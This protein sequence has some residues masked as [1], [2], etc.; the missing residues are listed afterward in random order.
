MA[1]MF[2]DT[3][4]SSSM[5][6]PASSSTAGGSASMRGFVAEFPPLLEVDR[7]QPSLKTFK[8]WPSSSDLFESPGLT[9]L[10]ACSRHLAPQDKPASRV[11]PGLTWVPIDSLSK[12]G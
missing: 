1:I 3:G 2:K 7:V 11:P 8:V 10:S 4:Q 12:L 9:V 5:P 6:Q